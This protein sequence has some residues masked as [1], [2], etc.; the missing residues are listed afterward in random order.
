MKTRTMV[1]NTHPP[2]A[3]GLHDEPL[4]LGREALAL[5]GDDLLTACRQQ[6]DLQAEIVL[7]WLYQQIKQQPEDALGAVLLVALMLEDLGG[8]DAG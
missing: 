3:A 5:A 7:A 1:D 6:R 4:A 8:I 2:M